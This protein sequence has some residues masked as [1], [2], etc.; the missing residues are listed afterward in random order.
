MLITYIM[1]SNTSKYIIIVYTKSTT[2]YST[3]YYA[4]Y[5]TLYTMYCTTVHIS[6][7][8]NFVLLYCNIF[9]ICENIGKLGTLQ[10]A[11]MY[12]TEGLVIRLSKLAVGWFTLIAKT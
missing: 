11:E 3:L 1:I 8:I 4:E 5:C 7:N 12:F 10:S 9:A 6:L 2:F